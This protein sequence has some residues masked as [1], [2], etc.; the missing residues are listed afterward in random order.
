[1]RKLKTVIGLSVALVLSVAS[2]RAQ[3]ITGSV[4]GPDGTPFRGAFIEAQN[5]K[6]LITVNVLSD[7]H[8]AYRIDNLAPGQYDLRIRAVGYTATSRTGIDLNR[9]G[10]MSIPVALKPGTVRWSD[11]SIYQ[12][13]KL[14]P[15]GKGK[16]VLLGSCSGCHSFQT[17]MASVHRDADGWK[18]RVNYMREITYFD[19]W[20]LTNEQFSDLTSYI[21]S[22][23]GDES[24]LP[25][26]PADLPE[27]KSLVRQFDDDAM[28]IVYVEYNM[29]GPSRMPFDANPAKDGSVW[30][31][32][33]SPVNSIARLNPE[34]GEVQEYKAPNGFP[35]FIHSAVAAPDGTVWFTEQ[36]ANKIGK[37][38]PS[39]KEITEYQDAYIPGL[40]RKQIGGNRHTLRIDS[41]GIIWCTGDPPVSFDPKT[42]KFTHYPVDPSYG[43]DIDKDDNVWV[44]GFD[45]E[46]K[47][48]RIDGKTGKLTQYQPTSGGLRRRIEVD[49][50]GM[51]YFAEYQA[52]KIAQFDPKTES[53]K[54]F[55]LPGPDSTPYALG[56]DKDHDIWYSSLHLDVVGRLN[57][58]TGQVTEFP[59]PHSENTLREFR[60]D[61]QGRMW[62]GT[63]ANNKVGYFLSREVGH[64]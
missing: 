45:K 5:E 37:W 51:V 11:I 40:E 61:A 30:I 48:S 36:A 55:A 13:S 7:A 19:T 38:D 32:E 56:I 53:F 8:G 31:P 20:R 49:T 18:D 50:D 41:K 35:A 2:S 29:P 64:R 9:D 22:L 60:K 26:S 4:K 1:M 23:F 34:T 10:N 47:L 39:T 24:I 17:R 62:Y 44:S 6:T 21:N 33:F 12:A 46:A 57:P 16:S 27:Y 3:T 25:I 15:E 59:F 63:P 28:K 58:K 43:I 14:F 42:K 52:G 54:E